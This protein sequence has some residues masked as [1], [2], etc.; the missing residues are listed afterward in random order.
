M[1]EVLAGLALKSLLI[2]GITLGLLHLTRKRSAS[3]RSLIAHFGLLALVALPLASLMLPSL[4]IPVPDALRPA[5]AIEE[6]TTPAPIAA[7]K[8]VT[9]D[10]TAT[11]PVATPTVATAATATPSFDW[12]PY[13]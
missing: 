13:A 12:T 10:S 5:P 3:E 8:A 9:V 6:V 7:D 1:I 2:A 11:D 4:N